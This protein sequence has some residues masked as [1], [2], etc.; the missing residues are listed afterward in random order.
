MSVTIRNYRDDDLEAIVELINAAG[1]VDQ[2]DLGTS[3]AELRELLGEPD[4][5]PRRTSS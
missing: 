1:A 2:L 3:V 5:H 4:Y